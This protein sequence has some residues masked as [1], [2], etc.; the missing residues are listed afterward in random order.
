MN[1]NKEYL[2]TTNNFFLYKSASSI[3]KILAIRKTNLWLFD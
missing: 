3:A 2:K 1:K